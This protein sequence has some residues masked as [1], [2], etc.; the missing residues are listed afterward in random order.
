[1][2]HQLRRNHVPTSVSL[3][4]TNLRRLWIFCQNRVLLLPFYEYAGANQSPRICVLQLS[5]TLF[6][7]LD[8]SISNEQRRLLHF[9]LDPNDV[10]IS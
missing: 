6:A 1:M 8:P 5:E 2:T 10:P 4:S 3:Q 9:R 7:V